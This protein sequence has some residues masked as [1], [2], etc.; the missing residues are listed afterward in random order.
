[1]GFYGNITNT[2]RT[3]F[4]FDK[5]F[6]NRAEMDG[7]IRAEKKD[8]GT[9]EWVETQTA[10]E[11]QEFVDNDDVFIGRY[12]LVDYDKEALVDVP[13]RRVYADKD[14]QYFY[15]S[16]DLSPSTIVRSF[17]DSDETYYV[18]DDN[19][20]YIINSK[21]EDEAYFYYIFRDETVYVYEDNTY[22]FYQVSGITSKYIDGLGAL[23]DIAVLKEVELDENNTVFDSYYSNYFQDRKIYKTL[24]TGVGRGWDST[25][26]QKVF[27]EGK[28]KYVMVAELNSVVP[29]FDLTVDQ[30]TI[31]PISPHFD[32][33]STN[34]YY[35]LH[36]QP[37]WGFKIKEANENSDEEIDYKGIQNLNNNITESYHGDIYYNKDGFDSSYHYDK[38]KIPDSINVSLGSSG[39]KYNPI[40]NHNNTDVYE[41][42]PCEDTQELFIHLSSLGDSVSAIWDIIYGTG[43]EAVL[44]NT[45]KKYR[46]NKDI[47]WDSFAGLRLVTSDPTGNGFLYLPERTETVAGCINSVHDLMGMIIVDD[48]NSE[49]DIKDALTNR[50]Y[51]RDGSYYIKD[52][53]DTL[54]E[55]GDNSE[56][57]ILSNF[58]ENLYY[59][60]KKN[61]YLENE[62]TYEIGNVYYKINENEHIIVQNLSDYIYESNKYF[63]L[64]N[65]SYLI[66]EK[67][68][69][70]NAREYYLVEA[71][72]NEQSALQVSNQW[73]TKNAKIFRP[74]QFTY[75]V[76]NELFSD[77]TSPTEEK[78][79]DGATYLV[80]NSK[81]L[82]Y[83]KTDED[84]IGYVQFDYDNPPTE[85]ISNLYYIE[86]Y[87]KAWSAEDEKYVPIAA[88]IGG[89]E[90]KISD[91]IPVV[92]FKEN[93]FY[94]EDD[95]GL[96]LVSFDGNGKIDIGPEDVRAD[97]YKTYLT[98][99]DA[100]GAY[101]TTLVANEQT[102]F[103]IANNYYYKDNTDY[104]LDLNV[105]KTEGIIY[106]KFINNPTELVANEKYYKPNKYYYQHTSGNYI[107]DTNNK[108]TEGREYYYCPPS[109]RYVIEGNG[110]Y[111]TGSVWNEKIIPIPDGVKLGTKSEAYGWKELVGFARSLNTIH[112]LILKI[113]NILKSDDLITRDTTTVQGCINTIND[114]INKFEALD[115][116]HIMIVNNYGQM[117]SAESN[118]DNWI[119][120]SVDP[121]EES[122]SLEHVGPVKGS[123]EAVA[124]VNPLFGESFELT[125][126]Y[127]DDKGHKFATKSH[128]VTLPKG[129]YQ[130]SN[131]VNGEK[132]ITG[133][134]FD[135]STGAI[136]SNSADLKDIIIAESETLGSR[137]SSLKNTIDQEVTDRG[138]AISAEATAREAAISAEEQAR[139]NADNL[140]AQARAEAVSAEAQARETKDNELANSITTL[141]NSTTTTVNGLSGRIENLENRTSSWDAAEKNVQSDWNESDQTSDAYILNKPDLSKVVQTTTEFSYN[142]NESM[143]SLTIQGLFDYIATLEARIKI[144]EDANSSS[145]EPIV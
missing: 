20:N 34:V 31:D 139:I 8:N 36:V 76:F 83:K 52:R 143:N 106:Y 141:S 82:F 53:Q 38:E 109:Q 55:N 140:E 131:Q 23:Y 26:W 65:G 103:Y 57:F 41:K 50:I 7:W 67:E 92:T 49:L 54:V 135:P 15:F 10:E 42:K 110:I 132:V 107:L 22:K 71:L 21:A 35:R 79:I 29:T 24:Q 137:L 77:L 119:A 51:Y 12:V 75:A 90:V 6:A 18:K 86:N 81:G 61:Y 84:K 13:Y 113:N 96:H 104:I 5:T 100:E 59:K 78:V 60:S 2:N 3:Q 121:V 123:V 125:D 27:S 138:S 70:V 122:I 116:G 47:S 68:E 115:P 126:H 62:S 16:K 130:D 94:Y 112:G 108:V 93:T 145:E 99:N 66:E 142:Y 95:S 144:L 28:A 17:K 25:V 136:A 89:Y 63:Y 127:F 101:T 45:D 102:P 85:L 32:A 37:S 43:K 128:T 11:A 74:D 39:A 40:F 118:G 64:E 72:K 58:P 97:S 105:V 48:A 46:R 134:G 111:T 1:M 9:I 14:K 80:G 87:Y 117:T 30:P 73:K 88:D 69:P 44:E 114:I 19:G 56:G 120:I 129:S 133:L 91:P 33:D 4:V 98:L 124:A